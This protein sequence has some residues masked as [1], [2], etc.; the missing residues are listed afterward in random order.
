LNLSRKRNVAAIASIDIE[1][2]ELT[3]N[4][5]FTRKEINSIVVPKMFKH[6]MLNKELLMYAILGSKERFGILNFSGK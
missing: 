6:N 1:T 2:G 4:T 5:L 3:R